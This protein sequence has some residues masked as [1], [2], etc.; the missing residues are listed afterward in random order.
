MLLNIFKNEVKLS[1]TRIVSLIKRDKRLKKCITYLYKQNYNSIE[2]MILSL[3]GN[4]QDAEEIF[5][6]TLSKVIWII[7]SDQFDEGFSLADYLFTLS[8]QMWVNTLQKRNNFSF[9]LS[10]TY[11]ENYKKDL[12]EKVPFI[13]D[14][15]FS[16]KEFR[17]YYDRLNPECNNELMD[18]VLGNSKCLKDFL[19]KNEFLNTKEYGTR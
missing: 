11:H 18:K 3:N 15:L 12:L 8:R 13:D 4:V 19:N 10:D 1:T 2:K 17:V 7:K 14:N 9:F 16:Q 6:Y 5:Q